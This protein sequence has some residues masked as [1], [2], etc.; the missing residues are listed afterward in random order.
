MN[1]LSQKLETIS[2]SK[3]Q[4][5]I[6]VLSLMIAAQ[7][8][9]IQHGWINPDSVLYIEAVKLFAKGEWQAGFS[10]FPWPLYSLCIV[11]THKFTFLSIHHA[12]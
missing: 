7:V 4:F 2:L 3:L 9:Y 12:A 10:V 11:A 6:V 5:Q 1:N 8:Q